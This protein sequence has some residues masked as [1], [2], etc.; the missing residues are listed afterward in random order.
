MRWLLPLL[1]IITGCE[2]SFMGA[3]GAPLSP[4]SP[5]L[6]PIVPGQTQPIVT[7]CTDT[8]TPGP[9]PLRR[10]SHEEYQ[11]ALVDLFGDEALAKQATTDFVADPVS[12]G[13]RNAARFLDVKPVLLQSYQAAA[14]LVA[15]EAVKDL[16]GLVPCDPSG[17]E[18]CARTF[19]ETFVRR[20]Y[21]RELTPEEVERYLTVFRAGVMG[22]DFKTG[23]EWV[24][25]TALQAP[26]FLY[27]PEVEGD[28][29]RTQAVSP[30]ELA[31]RLSFFLWQSIPD[32][33]LL[34]AARTGRLATKEDVEREARRM[35]ADPKA[36]RLFNFFEQWL[37][38]DE[39]VGLRRDATVFPGLPAALG[40]LLREEARE[41]VTRT[42]LDGD[43]S[44]ETLLA[45]EFSYV[46][47][48][49]A[50]HYGLSGITGSAFQRVDWTSGKRGGFFMT[51]GPLVSHDKQTRT[52]IVNRGL[53]V[54][55]LLL[56]QNIPAPPDNVPLNLG[57]IDSTASQGD[58][59]AAHRT[60]AAC[61]GCHNL[62]DPLGEPFENVDAVGRER[63]I[64][65]GGHAVKTA[66][67]VT[68][69]RTLDGPVPDGLTLMKKLAV[70]DEVRECVV[71][72]TFRFTA[73][74]E[75]QPAD[76]CSRQRTLQAFK[77]ANWNMKELFVAMTQT[78][79]F[80]MKPAITP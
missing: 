4:D 15:S 23:I 5:P 22:A 41:Y 9:A 50:Q 80:L 62:L 54:R 13:F 42:V 63:A 35:L 24:V 77:D 74:R 39:L 3:T 70:S 44:L 51:S 65:E 25:G 64:D 16:P 69:T 60:E 27:R 32:E 73:G 40:E 6:T 52:S 78:D 37:D 61:A 66:G 46:N 21:R 53:R 55:T 11:N 28:L 34:D 10:L 68:G 49:L 38:V 48:P 79:D 75:E 33:A 58:R 29:T 47:G 30:Y 71:T 59:L 14:E 43:G 17:G 8:P 57:P 12:L 7:A 26:N 19:I 2:G 18:G 56:C 72:Q 67:E 45:G 76:L 20:A 1:L 36:H 31:S